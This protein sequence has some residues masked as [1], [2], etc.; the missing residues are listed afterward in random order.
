M[1][2]GSQ[3]K[4]NWKI[5]IEHGD[6]PDYLY[7][8]SIAKNPKFTAEVNTTSFKKDFKE[9]DILDWYSRAYPHSKV[10]KIERL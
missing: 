10:I 1:A 6:I 8:N 5:T 4:S 7:E 3:N 9:K 2:F